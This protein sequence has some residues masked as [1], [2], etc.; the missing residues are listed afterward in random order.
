M[1]PPT[2]LLYQPLQRP[3]FVVVQATNRGEWLET[4]CGGEAERRSAAHLELSSMTTE[5][6]SGNGRMYGSTQW[7][8]SSMK[9]PVS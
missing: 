9:Q 2:C 8:K 3:E 4:L 5:H 6:G 1:Q 7:M